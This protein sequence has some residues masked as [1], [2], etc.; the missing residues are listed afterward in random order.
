MHKPRKAPPFSAYEGDEPFVFVTYSHM[1]TDP[2]YR[3]LT[4]L[5]EAEVNIWYDE[6]IEPGKRWRSEL[7]SALANCSVLLFFVT[8]N[9]VKSEHCLNEIEFAVNRNIAIISVYLDDVALPDIM[10]LSIGG[11][12][13]IMRHNMERSQYRE[14]LLLA[15]HSHLE[16][17]GG[18]THREL[19]DHIVSPAA[20]RHKRGMWAGIAAAAVIIGVSGYYFL[21]PSTAPIPGEVV[22]EPSVG[23][24][25]AAQAFNRGAEQLFNYATVADLQDAVSSFETAIELQEDHAEA[26][27][28]ICE[29]YVTQFRRT[30]DSK[31]IPMAEE[32]CRQAL[33]L[34]EN[35]WRVDYAQGL[36]A[37]HKG[38]YDT[39]LSLLDAAAAKRPDSDLVQAALAKTYT[40]MGDRAN[41]DVMYR[42]LVRNNPD[43]WGWHFDQAVHYYRTDRYVL[44]IDAYER[45]LALMPTN[46]RILNNLANAHYM[47]GNM[48]DA[49]RHWRAS[50]DIT[51]SST[52]QQGLAIIAIY[53][54][55]F[56]RAAVD[57]SKSIQL[58]PQ[59]YTHWGVLGEACEGYGAQDLSSAYYQRAARVALD[60]PNRNQHRVRALLG[61]YWAHSGAVYDAQKELAIIQDR[62][63]DSS[64]LVYYGAIIS[65]RLGDADNASMLRKRAANLGYP[66]HLLESDLH[67]GKPP[68]CPQTPVE[69]AEHPCE[70]L[71]DPASD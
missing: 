57:I 40:E 59:N 11:K 22:P 26:Y 3:Q 52:A 61:F 53:D 16:S 43:F 60:S 70:R 30:R 32:A 20:G 36:L 54:G 38:H 17:D 48:Q 9:S 66:Q 19:P 12:Q 10:E 68:A 55:C 14:R 5:N 34:D 47:I 1:D 15:L 7:A 8:D 41:A 2:V 4:W 62:H 65:K 49:E 69:S 33:I 6:G 24:G 46:H 63:M 67:L 64:A 51:P 25:D 39:A 31:Y 50:L 27:A 44:A 56:A 42:T 21:A 58:N 35:S 13:A 18:P 45:A 23:T 71:Y 37:Q 29:A 28:G